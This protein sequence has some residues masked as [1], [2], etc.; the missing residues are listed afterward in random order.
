VRHLLVRH[1]DDLSTA[2]QG[3]AIGSRDFR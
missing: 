3:I 1:V 2:L